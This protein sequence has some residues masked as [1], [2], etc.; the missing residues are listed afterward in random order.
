MLLCKLS[1]GNK[2]HDVI[3]KYL[4][5]PLTNIAFFA[6][7]GKFCALLVQ[8]VSHPTH[9]LPR[10]TAPQRRPEREGQAGWMWALL[11]MYE[12]RS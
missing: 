9:P 7:N 4:T 1:D 10:R 11:K 2:T 5:F 6:D 3:G 12:E 8:S